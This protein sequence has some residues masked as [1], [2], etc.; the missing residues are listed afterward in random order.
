MIMLDLM[1]MW[2]E[3]KV[4]S[5]LFSFTSC[6]IHRPTSLLHTCIQNIDAFS[7]KNLLVDFSDERLQFL[8][9]ILAIIGYGRLVINHCNFWG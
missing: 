9:L 7:K 3:R 5:S 4:S 1:K 2:L 6:D 8:V